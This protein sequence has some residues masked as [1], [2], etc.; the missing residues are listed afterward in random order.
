MPDARR[1][2]LER[3]EL[4]FA[5]PAGEVVAAALQQQVAL[6]AEADRGVGAVQFL[7]DHQVLAGQ[8]GERHGRQIGVARLQAGADQ[9]RRPEVLA[10]HACSCSRDNDHTPSILIRAARESR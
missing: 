3:G 4:A 1:P 10:E 2:R 8:F 6:G 5:R 7:L 9:V